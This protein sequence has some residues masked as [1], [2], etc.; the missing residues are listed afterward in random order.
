[1][2]SGG[3]EGRPRGRGEEDG[4]AVQAIRGKA[5]SLSNC[6]PPN[7]CFSNAFFAYTF[8][9]FN[10]L[11]QDLMREGDEEGRFEMMLFIVG[12][13]GEQVCHLPDVE[14][15]SFI[16]LNRHICIP[17]KHRCR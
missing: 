15:Q 9:P 12:S 8:S 16:S 13:H 1:M 7:F 4:E 14:K 3:A 6:P 11:D 2:Q 17:L 10:Y 5:T